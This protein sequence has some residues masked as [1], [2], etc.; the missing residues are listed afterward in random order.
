MLRPDVVWFGES[1]PQAAIELA[2]QAAYSA[3]V[4]LVAGTSSVVYPAAALPHVAKQHGARVI[5]VNLEVTEL[6][7]VADISLRGKCGEI[8]PQLLAAAL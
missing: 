8:L 4:F 5:E 6:S 1:L 3:E 2:M 7:S